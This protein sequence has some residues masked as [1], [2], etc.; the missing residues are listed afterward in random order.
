MN[1]NRL[2]DSIPLH[3][4]GAAQKPALHS[5][6]PPVV[7][8][9]R[10]QK[11]GRGLLPQVL[12]TRALRLE[13]AGQGLLRFASSGSARRQALAEA[14]AQLWGLQ[15]WLAGLRAEPFGQ[16]PL[17]TRC[18]GNVGVFKEALR[19]RLPRSPLGKT[20][21]SSNI[22]ALWGPPGLS[23]HG[24][25]PAPSQLRALL[26][27]ARVPRT[28]LSA[29]LIPFPSARE[30]SPLGLPSLGATHPANPQHSAAMAMDDSPHRGGTEP[31][32]VKAYEEK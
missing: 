10:S 16:P 14:G 7:A 21:C 18:R 23:G 1:W 26:K 32:S 2:Q 31:A 24:R 12:P 29:P 6:G 11:R 8:P 20:G 28:L 25:M 15:P 3:G 17:W 9:A 19:D 27:A 13:V 5:W 22:P 30:V 4:T